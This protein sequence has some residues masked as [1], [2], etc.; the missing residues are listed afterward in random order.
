MR[1]SNAAMPSGVVGHASSRKPR[2]CRSASS[3]NTS[4]LVP[5]GICAGVS[6][7][8]CPFDKVPRSVFTLFSM[9]VTGSFI[10]LRRSTCGCKPVLRVTVRFWLGVDLFSPG[11]FQLEPLLPDA[12]AQRNVARLHWLD[13][14]DI[15]LVLLGRLDDF[16]RQG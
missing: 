11:H 2:G 1:A 13:L 9:P 3:G 8:T 4:T 7:I 16:L 5:S 6:R 12:A 10:I 14:A 15:V